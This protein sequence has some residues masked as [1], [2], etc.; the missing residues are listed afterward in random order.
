MLLTGAI[1]IIRYTNLHILT[2]FPPPLGVRWHLNLSKIML[3][4]GKNTKD[5]EC[6]VLIKWPYW[7]RDHKYYHHLNCNKKVVSFHQ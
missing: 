7:C 4:K 1:Q 5:Q 2:P 3:L 6:Y